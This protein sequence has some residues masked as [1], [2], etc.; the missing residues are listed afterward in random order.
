MRCRGR[1]ADRR[2]AAASRS[3]PGDSEKAEDES[4]D[5]DGD[6]PGPVSIYTDGSCRGNPGPGGWGLVLVRGGKA[7][8]ERQGSA[9]ATTNNRMEFTAIIEALKL[10]PRGSPVTIFSDSK[11][12]VQTL[13]SWAAG[14][15]RRGWK[16]RDGEVKN[17]DLVKEAW[18]LL[19]ARPDVTVEWVAGHAGHRWNERAD[20]LATAYQRKDKAV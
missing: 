6:D 16:R 20:E 15:E 10:A 11:L 14:W 17:L 5:S 3:S 9:P 19:N 4:D 2:A 8:E 1:D 13:T 12:A 18:A 7:I